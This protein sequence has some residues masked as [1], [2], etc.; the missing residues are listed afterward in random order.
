MYVETVQCTILEVKQVR[1]CR[2]C[3]RAGSASVRAVPP[4]GQCLRA[5]RASVRAVPQCRQAGIV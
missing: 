1:R 3:L 4:C 5:G 2:K